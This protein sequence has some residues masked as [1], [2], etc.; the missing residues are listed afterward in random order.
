MLQLFMFQDDLRV[1]RKHASVTA[2]HFM[3][4]NVF[5]QLLLSLPPSVAALAEKLSLINN[6]LLLIKSQ[7]YKKL[8]VLNEDF[9]KRQS[10]LELTCLAFIS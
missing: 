7:D 10:L 6:T 4:G 9:F 1:A 2:T 8:I 3:F 5:T